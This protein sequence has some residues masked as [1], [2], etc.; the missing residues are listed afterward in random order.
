MFHRGS[1]IFLALLSSLLVAPAFAADHAGG[2]KSAA[3]SIM[4]RAVLAQSLS[5]SADPQ[6]VLF[7]SFIGSDANRNFP[8]TFKTRWVRGPGSVSVIVLSSPEWAGVENGAPVS[9]GTVGSTPAL[10]IESGQLPFSADNK[11]EVLI[12]RAQV[13]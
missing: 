11:N 13:I 5:V 1:R 9:V 2:F 6:A 7:N 10:E 3:G 12:V 8:V 4:L